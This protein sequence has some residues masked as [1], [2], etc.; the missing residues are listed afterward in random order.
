M[1]VIVWTTRSF[2]KILCVV[3]AI[4][5]PMTRN[6]HQCCSF[7]STRVE[8]SI[9][10]KALSEAVDRIKGDL[11]R[12]SAFTTFCTSWKC[13]C[14][15][16]YLSNTYRWSRYCTS[17]TIIRQRLRTNGAHLYMQIL[18]IFIVYWSN[19]QV[20]NGHDTAKP[21]IYTRLPLSSPPSSPL[22]VLTLPIS[23]LIFMG[24]IVFNEDSCICFDLNYHI[25]LF[26]CHGFWSPKLLVA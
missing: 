24:Y 2:H 16:T 6:I 19:P 3:K 13:Y 9:I 23:L 21:P 11:S 20:H 8:Y 14:T 5:L 10:D 4:R 7:H 22:I 18:R 15:H 26:V 12:R 25:N 1:C 17:Q